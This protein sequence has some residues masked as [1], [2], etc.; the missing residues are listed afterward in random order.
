[1]EEGVDTTLNNVNNK[2]QTNT[3]IQNSTKTLGENM[4]TTLSENADGE[5]SGKNFVKGA[6]DGVNN[7]GSQKGLFNVI[8]ALGKGMIAALNSSLDEHSP[9]K[10]TEESGINFVAGPIIGIQKRKKALLDEINRLGT[11][12]VNEF[13]NT[14]NPK[15]LNINAM[16]S[17]L[18]SSVI[19][20]TQMI[21]TT[22]TLNI[23]TKGEIN[24][25]KI[26]DEVNKIFGSKY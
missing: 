7:K 17:K 25:R 3:T 5:E 11:E 24:V 14:M 9:S 22:P 4:T 10:L 13:N 8:S 15:A 12:A 21:F 19:D 16:Q 23:Y 1:M 20:K 18:N 26:A 2:I 6:E